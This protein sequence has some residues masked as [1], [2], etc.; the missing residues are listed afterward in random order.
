MVSLFAGSDNGY[1]V[2]AHQS[3]NAAMPDIQADFFQLF[4]HPGPAVAAQAETGLFFDVR[5]SDKVRPLPAAGW[6][7][8]ESPQASGTDIHDVTQP[9]GGKAVTMFLDEPK[10]HGFWLAK[11]C[12]AFLRNS[13][14]FLRRKFLQIIAE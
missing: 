13:H 8:A 2:L 3:A 1:A 11:N 12:V 5:Q 7:V 9:V 4:C 14:V 6:T 10:P